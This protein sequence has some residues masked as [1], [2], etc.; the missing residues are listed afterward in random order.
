MELSEPMRLEF[1]MGYD[2]P[3]LLW[4]DGKPFFT[5]MNGINPCFPDES[6]KVASLSAGAHAIQVGMDLNH[7]QAWGFF[8]RFIRKDV[9]PAQIQSGKYARPIYG[10]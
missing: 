5:D 7:G 3:F 4:I 6:N 2:G 1:L 9:S 10:V 8:L